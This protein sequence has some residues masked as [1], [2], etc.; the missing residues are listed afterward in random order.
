MPEI[1][2]DVIVIGAGMAG[3]AAAAELGRKGFS[4]S[5]LEARERIGGRIHTLRPEGWE[6]PVELGAEFVH[7]GN[8]DLWRTL[9]RHRL[10]AKQVPGRHWMHDGEGLKRMDDIDDRIACITSKIDAK[11]IGTRSFAEFLRMKTGGFS[12]EEKAIATS[13]VE[14]FQAAPTQR[15]SARSVAGAT[16]DDKGQFQLPGGYDRVVAA[17]AASF[18]KKRV[19]LFARRVVRAVTWK[20]GRVVVRTA[21]ETFTAR[22]A[23]V[24][25]PLGV[26]QAKAGE[27]GAIRFDPP[28]RSRQK[29]VRAMGTGHVIRVTF[30]FD[31]VKWKT[32]LPDPLRS[33]VRVGFLHSNAKGVPVWWSMSGK[34]VVTGW[35][36]GPAAI[37]LSKR[38]ERSVVE[39]ALASLGRL[40][41][42]GKNK[43]KA[44]LRDYQTHNWTRDPFSRGAYTFVAAGHDDAA[45]RLR[46]PVRDTL[47]FAGEA[48]ADGEELGT[49]HGALSSGRRAAKEVITVWKKHRKRS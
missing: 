27:V 48:T 30:R 3:L 4:V 40:L 17:V 9:R 13:F 5:L 22:A 28:L 14:G 44:A 2:S 1:V 36:G 25:I 8:P 42:V 47:F 34:P 31:P 32:L 33:C 10:G 24:A 45:E 18:A 39:T 41:G 15:M 20:R 49:V 26:L 43:L 16:L 7:E 6:T 29:L 11:R 46:E 19:S 35:A 12:A 23:I 21:R 38:S 37:A